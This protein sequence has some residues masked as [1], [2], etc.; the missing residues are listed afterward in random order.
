MSRG[1]MAQRKEIEM[2]D[3]TPLT[4]T[5]V[6][7]GFAW[8]DAAAL[9]RAEGRADCPGCRARLAAWRR[10]LRHQLIGR[11]LVAAS[12]DERDA[13]RAARPLRLLPRREP[14]R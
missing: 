8:D 5:E 10:R 13:A 7:D 1:V 3:D 14:T 12:C 11:A 6:L 2:D 4:A 9:L